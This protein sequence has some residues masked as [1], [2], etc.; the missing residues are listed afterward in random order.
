M[1]SCKCSNVDL[2]R[3]FSLLQASCTCLRK[4]AAYIAQIMVSVSE[5]QLRPDMPAEPRG[6][7]F[8]GWAAYTDLI[9][10]CWAHDPVQRPTF[11]GV[12]AT[13]R[14][15]LTET[16]TLSRQR[17]LTEKESNDASSGPPTPRYTT[18]NAADTHIDAIDKKHC[19]VLGY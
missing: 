7:A 13:L 4:R 9:Q 12:I 14:E 15:L 2:Y 8:E 19:D 6:G 17:R 16:A 1:V 3:T 5:K 10:R 11:E 18:G